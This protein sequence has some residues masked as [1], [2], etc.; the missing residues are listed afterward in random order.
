MRGH[1]IPESRKVT[2]TLGIRPNPYG[3]PRLIF[4]N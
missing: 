3:V 4:D 1:V 2:S